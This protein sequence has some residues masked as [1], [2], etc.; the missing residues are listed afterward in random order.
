MTA[1]QGPDR[2]LIAAAIHITYQQH[3]TRDIRR[4]WPRTHPFSILVHKNSYNMES[5]MPNTTN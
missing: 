2:F 3:T 1:M 4:L 5:G